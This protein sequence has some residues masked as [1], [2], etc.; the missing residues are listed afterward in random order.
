MSSVIEEIV[1]LQTASAEQ[2][3]ASQALSQEV[4][5]KMGAIDQKVNQTAQDINALMQN[6]LKV[7]FYVSMTGNDTNSGTE[8]SPLLTISE[9]IK[10]TP[11]LGLCVISIIGDIFVVNDRISLNYKNLEIVMKSSQTIEQDTGFFETGS[12]SEIIVWEGKLKTK[13]GGQPSTDGSFFKRKDQ[14][15]LK[16]KTYYTDIELG[17]YNVIGC[18]NYSNG[19]NDISIGLCNL[20]LNPQRTQQSKLVALND[21]SLSMNITR[22]TNKT[23]IALKDL[24]SGIIRASDGNPINLITNTLSLWSN[25]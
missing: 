9:A 6:P 14:S 19:L 1:K 13:I 15:T 10:R 22:L 11:F 16:L 5:G 8:L 17:D 20:T 7:N 18:G 12:L 3:A 21:C 24:F 4:S 25:T 23:G 2:T